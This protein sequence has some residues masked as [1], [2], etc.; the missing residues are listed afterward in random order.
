MLFFWASMPLG[1]GLLWWTCRKH[2]VNFSSIP[3]HISISY[4]ERLKLYFVFN[5]SQKRTEN[6]FIKSRIT[7]FDWHIFLSLLYFLFFVITPLWLFHSL[8]FDLLSLP[9]LL[10]FH[11]C[12]SWTETK[13]QLG[14]L[15]YCEEFSTLKRKGRNILGDK[16]KITTLH[17]QDILGVNVLVLLPLISTTNN[18]NNNSWT[19]ESW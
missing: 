6:Q 18:I 4:S 9:L 7:S 19:Q 3:S 15:H 13:Q 2:T 8:F 16:T 14:R 11:R 1:S 12:L 5:L 10:L 17:N